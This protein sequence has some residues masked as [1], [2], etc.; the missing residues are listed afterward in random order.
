[1]GTK[2]YCD[3]QIEKAK[4]ERKKFA[5]ALAK[6]RKKAK[7]DSHAIAKLGKHVEGIDGVIALYEDTKR[8]AEQAAST[9]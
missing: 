4:A 2:E 6:H 1:M 9:P 5:D 7:R 8:L 3:E